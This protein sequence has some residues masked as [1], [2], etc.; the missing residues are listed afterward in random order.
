MDCPGNHPFRV[1]FLH[2]WPLLFRYFGSL[3]DWPFFGIGSSFLFPGVRRSSSIFPAT[4]GWWCC[5]EQSLLNPSAKASSS[6]PHSPRTSA[7][8]QFGGSL[9]RKERL[10]SRAPARQES[11]AHT[12]F[13]CG[14]NVL[15]PGV[16][17]RAVSDPCVGPAV[18]SCSLLAFLGPLA[19]RS[20]V[21]QQREERTLPW[22]GQTILRAGGSPYP[23]RHPPAGQTPSCS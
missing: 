16:L 19:P 4:W 1:R 5:A 21:Q 9:S 12:G 2:S 23:H 11:A 13:S 22:G 17:C 14:S 15:H 10:V 6:F 8:F 7:S 20:G 18:S 3:A